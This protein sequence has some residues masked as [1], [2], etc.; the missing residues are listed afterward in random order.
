MRTDCSLPVVRSLAETCRIPLASM[1]KVTSI[2]GMPRGA[3]GIP[4]SW[5]FPMVL[6]SMA[7]FRSP[8]STWISTVVWLSSAVEKTSCFFVGIVVFRSMSVGH[9]PAQ[10]LDAERER[11]HVEQEHIL[12]VAREH[13]ALDGR[14]H[15]HHLV[16]VHAAVRLLPEEVLHDLL[17][18][19]DP[20][21][22]AH[23]D[24]LVHVGGLE[25]RVPERRLHGLDGALDQVVHELLELGPGQ[26]HV[27]VL[28]ALL[29][30]GDEGEVDV[31]LHGG[32]EL[33]L[34][35]FGRLLEPLEGHGVLRQVDPLVLP[36]LLD[37]PVDDALVEVVTPQ[38]GVTVRGL[39]L[40]DAV[41]QLEDRRCRRFRLPGRRRRPSRPSRRPS[42]RARRRG[43][44]RWAR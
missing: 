44:L 12:H 43:R 32:A 15:G 31:G 18:L 9:D 26:R 27:Q 17:D 10:R 3:G 42:C 28:R 16:G 6:L 20:G 36:E 14:A 29:G 39:H 34:R 25:P 40:E 35:L 19:R 5:N 4:V 11:D 37:Q 41:A 38:V 21:R 7:I 23:Q 22:A 24:H 30:G 2:W 8:W 1:S 13:A 33:H